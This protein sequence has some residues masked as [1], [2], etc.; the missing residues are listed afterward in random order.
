MVASK[1]LFRQASNLCKRI[2]GSAKNPDTERTKESI[3]SQRVGCHYVW[4]I[5]NSVLNRE[6]SV[7]PTWFNG[8]EALISEKAKLFTELLSKNCNLNDSG[9]ELPASFLHMTISRAT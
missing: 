5:V 8:L 7:I 2:I 6:K 4:R 9:H 3:V 1:A